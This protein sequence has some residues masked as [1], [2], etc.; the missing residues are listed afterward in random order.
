MNFEHEGMLDGL[1]GKEREAREQL[2][3]HLVNDGFTLEELRQAVEEDRL[4]LL[5]VERVLGAQYTAQEIEKR[6]GMPAALM[7]RIRRLLGLPEAGPDDRIFGDED[8]E[9]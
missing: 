9:A 8:I 6:T 7:L 2:L 5:P 4:A 1:D 3:K